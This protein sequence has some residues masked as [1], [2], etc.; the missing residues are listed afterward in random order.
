MKQS[1]LWTE[2]NVCKVFTLIFVV[3]LAIN[4]YA[5]WLTPFLTNPYNLVDA[6]VITMSVVA[7]A[8]SSVP[9]SPLLP[10]LRPSF[11]PSL[12]H[13][14][15]PSLPHFSLPPTVQPLPTFLES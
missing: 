12:T 9:P 11:P 14:L 4:L 8:G 7:L 13:S 5:H 3:E 2:F 10:S 15:T 1:R 6:L